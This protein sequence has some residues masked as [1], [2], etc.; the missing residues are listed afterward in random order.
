M[1][2]ADVQELGSQKRLFTRQRTVTEQ[3]QH[4]GDLDLMFR[5]RG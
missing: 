3:A 4:A 5:D 2:P 1:S